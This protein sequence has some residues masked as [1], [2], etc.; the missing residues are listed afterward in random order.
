[1]N[2]PV[3]N[4]KSASSFSPVS[5]PD[6]S[7]EKAQPQG[8]ACFNKETKCR[9]LIV[10]DEPIM[11]ILLKK[12]L[13]GSGEIFLAIDG[14][15]GLQ[16]A[17]E[18]I[19]DLIVT[20]VMMPRK[21]GIEMLRDIRDIESLQNTPVVV[22]S[23]NSEIENRITGL[24]SGADD[25]ISKPFNAMELRLKV[26]SILMKKLFEK[27]LIKKNQQL[28]ATLEEL[29]ET[30][31]QLV[32]SSKMASIGELS[33]GMAH[34][35]NNPALAVSNAFELIDKRIQ[36]VEE[37]R[38]NFSEVADDFHKYSA[39]G[40]NAIERIRTIV[41][42]LLDFSRKNREHLSLVDIHEGIDSTLAIL[43]HQLKGVVEVHT[44]YTATNP[45][46]TDLMQLNQVFMCLLV[47]SLHAIQKKTESGMTAGNIWICT[48]Q[49]AKYT[50]L[51]FRDDGIG[52]KK[53]DL[54]KIFDPFFTTK[55]MDKGTGLGLNIS[56]RIIQASHGSIEV[57]SKVN[58]GTTFSL[59]L[60]NIQPETD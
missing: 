38:K 29:K 13:T 30:Q 3:Q 50:Y 58:V 36:Q 44:Q 6:S 10:E 51:S 48:S 12:A 55:A 60:P 54:D 15:E 52:I 21:D 16:K 26:K 25:Y 9:I 28:K 57:D 4:P 39:L 8:S 20:D 14:E 17:K 7:G 59:K 2:K 56:Y 18:L 47:N 11:Q 34:E 22:L 37:G 19:P 24:E 33:A 32:H 45:I 43:N 42:S 40:Q 1:M 53:Q 27:R 31:L 46:E 35:I 23:G 41:N 49:D 5:L